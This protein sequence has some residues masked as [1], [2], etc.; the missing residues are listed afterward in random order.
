MIVI[1][2]TISGI[3]Y[4]PFLDEIKLIIL[5]IVKTI[6]GIAVTASKG[7]PKT[8]PVTVAMVKHSPTLGV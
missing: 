7:T 6:N 8:E 1:L 2:K 4:A 3:F 5:E